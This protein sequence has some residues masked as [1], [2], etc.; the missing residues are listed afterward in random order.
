[1][2]ILDKFLDKF[3]GKKNGEKG[4]KGHL[5]ETVEAVVIA[6][7]LAI[8]IR[9]FV[10]QAFKIPS[11]SMEDT[12]LIGDHL[13]VSK[14][15]YGFQMPRPAF[16]R[17]FGLWVPFFETQLKRT[18]GEVE[19]GDVIVFRF[20]GD[21]KMVKTGPI[22]DFIPA[23]D[24]REARATDFIKR[25]LAVAGEEIEVV[26]RDIYINGEVFEDPYGVFKGNQWNYQGDG[27]GPYI[28]PEGHVFV[29]GDNR[30]NSKDSRFWGP[31][32]IRDIKGKAFVIYWSWDKEEHWIRFSRI[33]SRIH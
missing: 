16:I 18:W 8:V 30:N 7:V 15:S 32:P 25:V 10:I 5:R 14:F 19:R 23:E 28:V 12:L 17:V 1:M 22:I 9:T 31:V 13:I 21:R 27:F 3:K 11:G 20:P 24:E 29:M 33:L 4:K 26:G 2:S 6:V